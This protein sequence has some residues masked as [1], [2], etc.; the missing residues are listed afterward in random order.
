MF[1]FSYYFP[2]GKAYDYWILKLDNEGNTIWQNTIGGNLDDYLTSIELGDDEK[3]IANDEFR[4]AER[5]RIGAE[6]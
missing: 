6:T 4:A 5:V 2:Y 1:D 3:I